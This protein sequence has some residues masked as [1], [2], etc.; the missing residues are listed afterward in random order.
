MDDDDLEEIERKGMDKV[1]KLRRN[2]LRGREMCGRG[3]RG[4]SR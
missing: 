4:E 3:R 2:W 1:M